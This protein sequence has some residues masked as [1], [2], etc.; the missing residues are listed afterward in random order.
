MSIQRHKFIT[1]PPTIPKRKR[2]RPSRDRPYTRR[3][4]SRAMGH[5]SRQPTKWPL[6]NLTPLFSK[7][8]NPV[9]RI[10]FWKLE[11]EALSGL[12]SNCYDDS[13]LHVTA[14]MVRDDSVVQ[15]TVNPSHRRNEINLSPNE[16]E[17]APRL[18]NPNRYADGEAEQAPRLPN[19]NCRYDSEA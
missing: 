13:P 19:P 6:P 1:T 9:Q 18:P 7:K 12:G 5:I 17:R 8:K 3:F 15:S 2:S 16:A 11:N 4:N 14:M 10:N